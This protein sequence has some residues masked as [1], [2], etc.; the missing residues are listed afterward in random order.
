MDSIIA[1]VALLV[2]LVAL[3]VSVMTLRRSLRP[4][5]TASVRTHSSG[6]V[7]I[8]YSLV[9]LN[10]GSVPAR[11]VRLEVEEKDLRAALGTG[12]TDLRKDMWLACFHADNSIPVLQ[13]GQQVSCSFGLTNG[14]EDG[15]WKYKSSI[16]IRVTYESWFGKKHSEVQTIR[17]VDSTSFTGL[18]WAIDA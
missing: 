6:N 2:S 7:A 13:N 16:A 12:A 10:S 9:L 4:L 15:F 5:V 8:T 18:S 3:G 17:I 11:N 1:I 14:P